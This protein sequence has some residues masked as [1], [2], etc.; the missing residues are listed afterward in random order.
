MEGRNN[1]NDIE[2]DEFEYDKDGKIRI[3]KKL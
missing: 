2:Y 3:K 1:F